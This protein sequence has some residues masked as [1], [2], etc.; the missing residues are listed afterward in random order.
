M[1]MVPGCNNVVRINGRAL[2]TVDEGIIDRF[3]KGGS[4]P[5]TVIVVAIGEMYFQCAKA[6]M[7]SELWS[8]ADDRHKVP[9]AGDFIKEQK[10]DF[11]AGAY[12]REYPA[13]AKDK[14]W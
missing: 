6:L 1:F 11:D 8:G 3:D 9:T 12:D 14:M 7:R 4:K 10:S 2:L 5:A 13:Y